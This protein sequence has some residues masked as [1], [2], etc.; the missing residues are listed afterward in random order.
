MLFI[1]ETPTHVAVRSEIKELF[2]N[3]ARLISP[4]SRRLYAK[5]K[6]GEAPEFAR[7]IGAET[8]ALLDRPEGV[9]ASAWLSAYDSIAAQDQEGW[10][11]EE[12]EL[13]ET[14]LVERGYLHVEPA[15]LLAPYP[16]YDK[17]R[18]I[19]GQRKIEHAIKDIVGAYESAGFDVEHAVAYERENGDSVEVIAAL[20]A[21]VETPETVDEEQVIAA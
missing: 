3:K 10:T 11:D 14:T 16:M 15:R 20:Q 19:Q 6:R 9:E 1:N 4:K 18:Q 12:R 2:D 17:H 7:A 21:L 13:I 8:F 5:F